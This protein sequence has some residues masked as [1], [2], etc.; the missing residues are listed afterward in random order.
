[1]RIHYGVC[2][3]NTWIFGRRYGSRR[4]DEGYRLA[5]QHCRAWENYD[6]DGE[7]RRMENDEEEQQTM[8]HEVGSYVR[9]IIMRGRDFQMPE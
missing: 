3:R 1:M 9:C 4:G 6:A 2:Q 8:E 5:H 7:I